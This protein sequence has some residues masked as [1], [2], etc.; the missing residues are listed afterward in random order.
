MSVLQDP[1]DFA[2][3]ICFCCAHKVLM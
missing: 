3:K 2:F 1:A